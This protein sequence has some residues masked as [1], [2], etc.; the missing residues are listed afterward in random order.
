MS[1]IT[2]FTKPGC[3]FCQAA[4]DDLNIRGIEYEEVNVLADE[5]GKQKVFELTGQYNVPVILNGDDVSIGFG[6][7]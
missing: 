5:K 3:P 1:K 7:Y 4:K 6:G 2:I